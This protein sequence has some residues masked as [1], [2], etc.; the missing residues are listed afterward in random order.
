M[1][2]A[3]CRREAPLCNSHIIPEFMYQPLYDEKHRFFGI[4]NI[5]SKPSKLFQKGFRERLLCE[6]CE[7]RLSANE[8]YANGVFFGG[9][10]KEAVRMA[11]GYLF[12][13]LEYRPLK[14][15]LMS[16]LW[17]FSATSLEQFKG[18]NLGLYGE[19]L[20]ALVHD[21]DPSDSLS[22]PCTITGV[23]DKGRH[24]AGMIMQPARMRIESHR[25]WVFVIAGFVFHFFVCGRPPPAGY[26]RA[27]LQE[28]GRMLVSVCDVREITSLRE[29]IIEFGKAERERVQEVEGPNKS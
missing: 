5:P 21:G 25:V 15:F 16:L 1:Q 11:T 20:R 18:V 8:D 26:R 23:L 2:C 13:N 10:A 17:R 9:T 7:G 12:F 4:S 6:P 3:L 28:D 24:M 14:L 29:W 27:F 19:R 22:F